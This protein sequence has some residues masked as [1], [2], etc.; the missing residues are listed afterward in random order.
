MASTSNNVC[1]TRLDIAKYLNDSGE[2][3]S[4]Q[5]WTNYYEKFIHRVCS[6][7]AMKKSEMPSQMSKDISEIKGFYQK[8]HRKYEIMVEKHAKFFSVELKP[9]RSAPSSSAEVFLSY[10]HKK[11]N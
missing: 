5:N 7:L 6:K 8:C 2:R 3:P 1:L 4:N 9:K 10:H 11:L